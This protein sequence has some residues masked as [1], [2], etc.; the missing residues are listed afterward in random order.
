M[1]YYEWKRHQLKWQ[2]ESTEEPIFDEIAD[3]VTP[4]IKKHT[5]S[6]LIVMRTRIV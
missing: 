2:L 6:I 1:K 4:R 5:A 3:T